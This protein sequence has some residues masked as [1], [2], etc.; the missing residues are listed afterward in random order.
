MKEY[1][2]KT[3][4]FYKSADEHKKEVQEKLNAYAKKGWTLS[5][6]KYVPAEGFKSGTTFL[7]L[8]RPASSD[9]TIDLELEPPST[10][11]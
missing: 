9:Q 5:A 2:I 10:Y 11:T 4:G 6:V 7:Y 1:L 3:I 8:E